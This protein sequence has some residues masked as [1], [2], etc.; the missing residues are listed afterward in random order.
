ATPAGAQDTPGTG[1]I[2]VHVVDCPAGYDEGAYYATCHDNGIIGANVSISGPTTDDKNTVEAGGPGVVRFAGIP[3]GSYIVSLNLPD[4]GQRYATYCSLEGSSVEVVLSP[5][6]SST[7]S[8]EVGDGQ[9]VICD[10]YVI[11]PGAT[12]VEPPPAEEES[13]APPPPTEEENVA[14]PPD[15][16]SL[17]IGAVVCPEDTDADGGYDVLAG[18]CVAPAENVTFTLGSGGSVV[19]TANTDGDPAGQ[20]A[21]G[22]L[23]PGTY[24]VY[25]DVPLEF[26]QE[27]LFCT[28]DGGALYE[29]TFSENGVATFS[30]VNG[31]DLACDW[32]IVPY[33]LQGEPGRGEETDGSLTVHLAA[34]PQEYEGSDFYE[35]CHGNGIADQEFFLTGPGVDTS[36]VTAMPQEPGPGIVEFTGLPAGEYLLAGGPPGD[37]GTVRLFCTLQPDGASVET[38]VST[39]QAT[40][41]IGEGE[42]VLCDWY[43]IP[44]DARGETPTPTPTQTP[45]P[46]TRAEI[47]VTLFACDPGETMAG[48]SWSDFAS[49]C[50]EPRDGVTFR[51]GDPAAPPLSAETG[52]SGP[53]KV[54]FYDLLPA[55]YTLTPTL[56]QGLSSAA[57]FC[58]I[59]G[60]D[61]Y[62]KNL[63]NGSTTFVNVNGESIACDWFATQPTS[64]LAPQPTGPSGAIA[65]REFLC[66]TDASEI[67][68][69]ERE[70]RAGS[71][72]ATFTAASI[73][74]AITL[75]S[76]T[77]ATGVAT[78]TA[79]PDGFYTLKQNEGAWCKAKAERVDSNSRVIVEN[80]QNTNVFIYQCS[81]VTELPSTGTGSAI[82][83]MDS[84]SWWEDTTPVHQAGM[85]AGLVGAVLL[86]GWAATR[87]RTA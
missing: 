72:G 29:K 62:Q 9:A 14:P 47:I 23:A 54:R 11:P 37:F 76:A 80:G 78:F 34:C 46:P 36:A 6:N 22:D 49:A 16:A 2:E 31:E 75:T 42:D 30:D 39:T 21:F 38:Q 82:L 71:S 86:L 5:G 20:V 61:V 26:A 10:F 25:S 66:E 15:L 81:Q 55:D 83:P 58:R 84:P 13:V 48:A 52:I 70:C 1:A 65:V 44:E 79:L 32:Y 68:D 19:D 74:G 73:D 17:V 45:E 4:T 59:D 63:T 3:A 41:T 18:S 56:P 27:R 51:L 67:D 33:D 12:V 43:Y 50:D 7:G 28:A 60:G 8:I 40:F 77:N 64:Q 57:V 69:W 87:Q 53:G 35:D 85:G 24:T